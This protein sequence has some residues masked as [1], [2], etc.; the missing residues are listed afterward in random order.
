[1]DNTGIEELV[2]GLGFSQV[3]ESQS[4]PQ[5]IDLEVLGVGLDNL[6]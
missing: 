6:N 2:R 5:T 4:L 3:H 1:M